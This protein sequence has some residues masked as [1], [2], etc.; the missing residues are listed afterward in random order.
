MHDKFNDIAC[1][2]CLCKPHHCLHR[3]R[4]SVAAYV[5]GNKGEPECS[6]EGNGKKRERSLSFS[7]EVYE[8][9]WE[10]K[11]SCEWEGAAR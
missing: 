8:M 2:S 5:E 4:L 11:G 6:G 7:S 1:H 10:R 9:M 3:H